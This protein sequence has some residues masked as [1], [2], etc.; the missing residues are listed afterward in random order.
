MSEHTPGSACPRGG[1]V[2]GKRTF[3]AALTAAALA[4][5]GLATTP[6]ASAPATDCPAAYPVAELVDGQPV[7]GL[8][9]SKGTSPEEFHGE[10]V[11]VIDDG[12]APEM[13]LIIVELSSPAI[14]EAG[15]V[16]SGMPGS[17][18]YT[19]D[20]DL[21]GAVSYGLSW[22]S[23][24]IAGVTPAED[25]QALLSSPAADPAA[26][27]EKVAVPGTMAREMTAS[28]AATEQQAEGG[29][30]RLPLPLAISGLANSKRLDQAAE[31][32]GL[33]DV[34]LYRAGTATAAGA[35]YPI[36]TGGNLAASLSYGDLT[37]MGVGTATAICGD[38]VLAFG[39]P[40]LYDG[41]SS[42]TMH[43][44]SAVLVQPDSLGAPFKIANGGAPQGA[45]S[46]DRMAGILGIFGAAP[47]TTDVTS[48]VKAGAK[49][50]TGATRISVDDYVPDLS[51]FHLLVD[52]DRVFD[53]IGKGSS[54]VDWTVR[55]TRADGT[56][57]QFARTDRF[58]SSWDISG[59]PAWELWEQ[60]YK[61]QNNGFEEVAFTG[62]RTSSTM[63]DIFRKYTLKKIEVRG[64]GTWNPVPRDSM[65]RVKA[66]TKK[67]FR[68]T[69]RSAQL[70]TARIRLEV[71]IPRRAA[72]RWGYIE[73]FGGSS[74]WGDE[75]YYDEGSSSAESL[76]EVLREIRR[77]PRNDNVVANLRIY[78]RGDGAI[79]RSARGLARAV[80][81][82][83]RS[84]EIRVVR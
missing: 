53:A 55:G 1:L 12:I 48:Y 74:Y 14:E 8:T 18:V 50:R 61:V 22:G 79:T 16:W 78:G 36:V 56:T 44:A 71:P 4:A 40:M 19:T 39:H 65:L 42:L 11:G 13:D 15:G 75:Y 32:L 3:A 6:A 9:V 5:T 34:R 46:Q 38:E 58:A 23:S 2:R 17:P 63:N 57:F 52:Q 28:G 30:K 72:R 67:R 33:D 70:G 60:L 64:G 37:A 54:L 29:M 62:V 77:A 25:M 76:D 69:L 59:E 21:I 43:G 20:G 84:V 45:I 47:A 35:D 26:A 7:T 41:R 83:S 31:R 49:E 68:V 51:A 66:G 82:G 81:S 73:F 80:V 27:Q 10:V 24:P